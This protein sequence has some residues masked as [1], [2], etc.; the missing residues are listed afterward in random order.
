MK[1]IITALCLTISLSACVTYRPQYDNDYKKAVLA[2]T[3]KQEQVKFNGYGYWHPN[4]SVILTNL[5]LPIIRGNLVITDQRI[6]FL[7]WHEDENVYKVIKRINLSDI[8]NVKYTS[9]A[10][11]NAISIEQKNEKF[12]MFSYKSAIDMADKD[13]NLQAIDYLK[14]RIT[15]AANN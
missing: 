12:E 1:K 3:D 4:M 13:K 14:S 6:Y 10:L 8:K 2:I 7:E 5:N 9:F 11:N 15:D